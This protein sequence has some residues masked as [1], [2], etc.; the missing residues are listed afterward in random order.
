MFHHMPY[1]IRYRVYHPVVIARRR[2]KVLALWT[3][4]VRAR[5]WMLAGILISPKRSETACIARVINPHV[6]VVELVVWSGDIPAAESKLAAHLEIRANVQPGGQSDPKIARPIIGCFSWLRGQS[7]PAT[8]IKHP[9]F[10]DFISSLLRKNSH[11]SISL[12]DDPVKAR[13]SIRRAADR[14][15]RPIINPLHPVRRG[16]D[17]GLRDAGISETGV[18]TVKDQIRPARAPTEIQS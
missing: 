9:G 7:I 6:S 18:I 17:R 11:P 3:Q 5:R 1:R 14:F 2:R 16:G 4:R 12:R 13:R 15:G 10:I 8:R